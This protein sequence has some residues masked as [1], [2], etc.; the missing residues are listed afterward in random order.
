[1]LRVNVKEKKEEECFVF[2]ERKR[3]RWYRNEGKLE[4]NRVKNRRAQE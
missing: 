3:D 1:M 4:K 2:N